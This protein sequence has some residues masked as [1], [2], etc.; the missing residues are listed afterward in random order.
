MLRGSKVVDIGTVMPGEQ[1]V[2]LIDTN[3]LIK[4]LYPVAFDGN[5]REYEK[6]YAN[7]RERCAELLVTS[8]Q[9]SEFINRCIRFQ[10]NLYKEVHSEAEDFKRDYRQTDDYMDSMK[11]ILEIVESDIVP[12]FKFV[13]DQFEKICKE[14]IFQYG[15]SYDFN[16][17]LLTEV[18]KCYSA[19]IVT[20]D[21]DFSNYVSEIPIV[22]GN[23]KLL[24]W[25][26]MTSHS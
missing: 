23:G 4:I 1:D 11:S 25:A 3:I 9:L 26:D 6:F 12:H 13:S 7:A 20:D 8:I 21:M 16:D 24:K 10:F 19:T 5:I 15:F 14:N 22:T 18:A 17:A 2:Y